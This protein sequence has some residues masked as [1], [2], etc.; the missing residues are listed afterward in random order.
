M[1]ILIVQPLDSIGKKTN[2]WLVMYPPIPNNMKVNFK[3][4]P[5][6][7]ME[8]IE[9]LRMVAKSCT[10]WYPLVNIQKAIENGHL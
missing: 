4:S 5:E 2:P 9:V 8:R 7:R 6:E 10:S 3:S 1:E